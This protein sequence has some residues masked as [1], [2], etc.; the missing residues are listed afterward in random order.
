MNQEIYLEILDSHLIPFGLN[1][2]GTNWFLHQ[3]NDSKHFS[4]LCSNYL[5]EN[6]INWV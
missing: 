2:Y 4:N 6:R 3:D 5:L 1:R